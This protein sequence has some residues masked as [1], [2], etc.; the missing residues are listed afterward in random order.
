MQLKAQLWLWIQLRRSVILIKSKTRTSWP[1]LKQLYRD[2]PGHLESRG[3]D[4]IDTFHPYVIERI[5]QSHFSGETLAV[6]PEGMN[7]QWMECLAV[8]DLKN[9]YPVCF[10]WSLI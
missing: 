8:I 6:G 10:F 7:P 4:L 2:L 1:S 9:K 5:I 3:V